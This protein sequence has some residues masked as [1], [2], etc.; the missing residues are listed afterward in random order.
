MKLFR[1]LGVVG[2]AWRSCFPFLLRPAVWLPFLLIAGAQ[3]VALIFLLSFYKPGILPFALPLVRLVGGDPATHYPTF[4]FVL[5]T[6]FY[7]VDMAIAVFVSSLAAGAATMLFAKGF[8]TGEGPTWSVAVRRYPALLLLSAIVTAVLFG[9]SQVAALVPHDLILANGSVRWGLRLGVLLMLVIAQSLVVYATAWIVL[10]GH[11]LLPAIRD[12]IRVSLRTFLPTALVVGAPLLLL[13]PLGY[14]SG[15]ADLFINKF[16]PDM[17]GALL[18]VRI[19][20]EIVLGF[21]LIGG[22]TRLFLWRL[23]GATR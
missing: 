14:L 19:L 1:S 3:A 16:Q 11:R 17:V 23:A 4:Y 7:R 15:R 20:V 22:V 21:F 12:S 8:G 9:L 10:K 5:P 18:V 6:V 13:F 2:W